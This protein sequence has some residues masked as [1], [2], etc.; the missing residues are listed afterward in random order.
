MKNIRNWVMA[1]MV[2]AGSLVGMAQPSPAIPTDPV[3]EAHI[4]KWLKKMTLEEKVGQMCEITV[5]VI[6]DFP[7]SKDGFKLSEAMLDTVIGKYKVGSILNVPL[8][9]AQKRRY[10][11]PQSV[12]F[13]RSR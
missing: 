13:R 5:D 7:G 9:V 11:L 8:S 1:S 12:R 3:I 6:T 2:C 4:Q 10:G